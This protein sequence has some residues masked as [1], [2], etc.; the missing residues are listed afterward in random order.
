MGDRASIFDSAAYNASNY[1]EDSVLVYN[2]ISL[3]KN[4]VSK[5]PDSSLAWAD[6]AIKIALQINN[7]QLVADVV[8]QKHFVQESNTERIKNRMLIFNNRI[9]AL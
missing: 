5:N 4:N 9:N 1:F 2:Y 8:E 3:S 6:L 7:L